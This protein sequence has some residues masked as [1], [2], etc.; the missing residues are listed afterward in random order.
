M[1][2]GIGFLGTGVILQVQ[3]RIAGLIVAATSWATA[4]I[5][6]ASALGM[7]VLAPLTTGLIYG[8]MILHHMPGWGNFTKRYAAK[9][10][11]A[12]RTDWMSSIANR[13]QSKPRHGRSSLH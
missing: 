4:V 9:R 2:T 6:M 8:M 11:R 5:S 13:T 7:Y 12:P 3:G 10:R 1:V